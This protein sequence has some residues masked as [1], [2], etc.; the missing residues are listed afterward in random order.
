MRYVFTEKS[1]V[2]FI[3]LAT[4]EGQEAKV[5]FLSTPEL[6]AVAVVDRAFTG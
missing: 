5:Q 1:F 4:P 6:G 2:E 3:H